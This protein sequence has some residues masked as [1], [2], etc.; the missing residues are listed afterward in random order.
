MSEGLDPVAGLRAGSCL[1]DVA[2]V[3]LGSLAHYAERT[4]KGV[5]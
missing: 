1:V 5:Q 2:S 3:S 4:E